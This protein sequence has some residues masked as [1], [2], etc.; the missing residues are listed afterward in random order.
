MTMTYVKFGGGGYVAHCTEINTWDQDKTL[1]QT[2][3]YRI[4]ICKD[5]FGSYLATYH[6][7]IGGNQYDVHVRSSD[8]LLSWSDEIQITENGNSHDPYCNI[9]P[10]GFCIYYAKYK[11]PAY[12]IH[13]VMSIN[14]VNWTEEEQITFDQT[15]NTQPAFFTEADNIYLVWTHAIDYDT[16]NDIYFER[17][18][19]TGSSEYFEP[20]NK[21]YVI[22]LSD[23][24]FLLTLPPGLAGR[25]EL[26]VYNMQGQFVEQKILY[27]EG[28][29]L[30]LDLLLKNSGVYLFCFNIA[31]KVLNSKIVIK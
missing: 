5:T 2:G 14:G 19:I 26:N 16:D 22:Q 20:E 31:G 15:N 11:N 13:R 18:E 25:S 21:F 7:N 23:Q 1:I 4:R 28:G 12:N 24:N 17:Y 3:A 27:F 29:N 8:D 30:Q 6:R 10:D 9:T